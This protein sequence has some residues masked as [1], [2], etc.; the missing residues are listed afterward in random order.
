VKLG[1]VDISAWTWFLPTT[2]NQRDHTVHLSDFAIGELEK[3]RALREGLGADDDRLADWVFPAT[4][5]TRPVCIKSFGKQL[6]DR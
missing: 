2:K 5:P 3:L 6:A 1:L 4:N